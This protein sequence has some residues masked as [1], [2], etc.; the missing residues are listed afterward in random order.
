MKKLSKLTGLSPRTV[1][2]H[3]LPKLVVILFFNYTEQ[4]DYLQILIKYFW[5]KIWMG[6]GQFPSDLFG[7][8]KRAL[9]LLILVRM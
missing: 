1:G 8:F 2:G 6:R 7:H 5:G 9:K 4:N 3:F